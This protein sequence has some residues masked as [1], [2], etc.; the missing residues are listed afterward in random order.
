[1]IKI[2]YGFLSD[3]SPMG[4]PCTRWYNSQLSG[5]LATSDANLYMLFTFT[6]GQDVRYEL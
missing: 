6:Y 4:Y 2:S 1:M 5:C 3:S